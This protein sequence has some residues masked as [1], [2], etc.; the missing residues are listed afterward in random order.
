MPERIPLSTGSHVL[1]AISVLE[2][3]NTSE[4]SEKLDIREKVVADQV[5]RLKAE[6]FV[7]EPDYGKLIVNV[8]R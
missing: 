4:I 7:S 3:T 6:G 8:E 1:W 5:E 2:P